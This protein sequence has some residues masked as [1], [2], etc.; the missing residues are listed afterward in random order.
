MQQLASWCNQHLP[1]PKFCLGCKQW[2][3]N[4]TKNL[5]VQCSASL[6][7]VVGCPVCNQ[8][9]TPYCKSW[10]NMGAEPFFACFE[11]QNL[12]QLWLNQLKY[13]HNPKAFK[14]LV[15]LVSA[16]IL[17]N[18]SCL[19]DIHGILAIPSHYRKVVY[20]G[21]EPLKDL[22]LG[23]F[24]TQLKLGL[25][26]KTK[27]TSPQMRKTRE[28]RLKLAEVKD[29]YTFSPQ[30]AGRSFLVFD[31]VCTTGA[32]LKSFCTALRHA[33]AKDIKALVLARNF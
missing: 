11:Y 15:E 1:L 2:L 13:N 7:W 28:A 14:L 9:H 16:W 33:G 8:R 19:N 32:T 29:L 25:C 18:P 17:K 12:I 30:V 10:H 24:G 20:R 31:D 26:H 5:C 27:N 22:G 4:S 6:P 23:I 3:A 21:F